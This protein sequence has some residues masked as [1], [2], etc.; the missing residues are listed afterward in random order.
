MEYEI[1]DQP[2]G[3]GPSQHRYNDM[4]SSRPA[5]SRTGGRHPLARQPASADRALHIPE[6]E[7]G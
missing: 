3:F 4:A 6:Q 1:E 5:A 2:Q 7:D